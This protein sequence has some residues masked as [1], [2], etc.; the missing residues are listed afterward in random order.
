MMFLYSA[1]LRDVEKRRRELE[2]RRGTTREESRMAAETRNK[3]RTKEGILGMRQDKTGTEKAYEASRRRH[4][5][6]DERR[7]LLSDHQCGL[8]PRCNL[9]VRHPGQCSV[10]RDVPARNHTATDKIVGPSLYV[11]HKTKQKKALFVL[12]NHWRKKQASISART[13]PPPN[14]LQAAKNYTNATLPGTRPS[15]PKGSSPHP[16]APCVPSAGARH[17]DD[18]AGI[19]NVGR[20]LPVGAVLTL[21]LSGTDGGGGGVDQCPWGSRVAA[22]LPAEPAEGRL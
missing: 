14:K 11:K 8:P 7:S 2:G 1:I 3:L 13:D 20:D 12:L 21:L 17:N 9:R 4:P 16:R 5:R 19:L 10:R 6:G 18:T 22:G 15:A